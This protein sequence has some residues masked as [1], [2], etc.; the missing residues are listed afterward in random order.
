MQLARLQAERREL[1]RERLEFLRF[2]DSHDDR[3]HGAGRPKPLG[4]L[5]EERSTPAAARPSATLRLEALT[6]ALVDYAQPR[7][8]RTPIVMD[9]AGGA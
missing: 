1:E 5:P 4:P 3:G 2:L 6:P 9:Y 8:E 7:R